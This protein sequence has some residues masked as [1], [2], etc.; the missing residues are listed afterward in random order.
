M[1][2][3]IIEQTGRVVKFEK[4][5]KS[6]KSD[7]TLIL[8]TDLKGLKAG[9]SVAVNGACL[10]VVEFQPTGV[11]QFFVSQETL[12]KTNLNQLKEG[13]L[14]NLERAMIVANRLSGHWVQGHVD[15]R[16][17]CVSVQKQGEGVHAE[18]EIPQALGR[19]CVDKGSITLNGVS[20]TLNQVRDLSNGRVL[21]ST[22]LIPF[23][24]S[25][26]NLCELKK[27]DSINV[28][29]DVL[30]KYVEKLCQPYLKP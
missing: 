8:F 16:G 19:Y 24:W 5:K 15:G 14:V 30:A 22:H 23:T 7:A 21:L 1:F 2:T 13:S 9:E 25:H 28:E 18:F 17:E 11:I 4:F 6:E 3:G 12:E 20:L 27:G 26:T 10:T 29:V